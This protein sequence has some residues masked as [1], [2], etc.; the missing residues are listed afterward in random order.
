MLPIEYGGTIANSFP[1]T[2]LDESPVISSTGI[3][4]NDALA[5][6]EM[7]AL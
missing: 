7:S 6:P 2:V 4:H 5:A 1:A 3:F